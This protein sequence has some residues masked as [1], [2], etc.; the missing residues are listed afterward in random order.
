MYRSLTADA[1][2]QVAGLPAGYHVD[3]LLATGVWDLF[4]DKQINLVE[5][6][7]T[8]LGHG[9]ELTRLPGSSLG[10]GYEFRV[11]EKV[12]W[13]VPV[14]G[15]AVMSQYVHC[16]TL[17]GSQKN[18]LFGTVGG[19]RHGMRAGDLIV[20][21]TSVGNDNALMY[22]RDAVDKLFAPDENLR[23]SLLSRI[24]DLELPESVQ[25]WQGVTNTCEVMFAESSD[26]VSQW[27]EEGFLGVE[28]EAA[29]MFALSASFNVPAAA[30]LSVADNLIEDESFF[31]ES[32]EDSRKLRMIVKQLQYDVLLAELLA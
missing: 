5:S 3:G 31:S 21:S 27:S 18:L 2:R 28:M 8:S 23:L 32:Y 22:Q 30:V 6:A 24:R 19:L 13:W 4:A 11:A 14:M 20:P 1:F 12:F 17:L 7:L 9:V 16:A 25:L 26:D 15:T 10:H 29:M